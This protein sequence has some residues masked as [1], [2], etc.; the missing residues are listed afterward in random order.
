[1]TEED[2]K[3]E[4]V[5]NAIISY[6]DFIKEFKT[7]KEDYVITNEQNN[8]KLKYVFR[9]YNLDCFIIDKKYLDE[10]RK[11]TN[12]DKLTQ[13]LKDNTEENKNK[14]KKKLTEYLNEN[15]YRFDEE[16][17]KLYS[18]EDELKGIVNNFNSYS[19]VN[20]EICEIMGVS[21][22]LLNSNVVKISKNSVNT[23]LLFSKNNFIISINMDKN[24]KEN[25]TNENDEKNKNKAIEAKDGKI[26]KYKNLY[27]VEEITK[28]I[29]ALL[30]FNE[31]NIQNK[32][33][34]K[35]KDIYNFKKYYLIKS[36]WLKEYKEHFLYDKI[37]KIISDEFS[38]KNFT[39]KKIK[40]FLNDI[41]KSKIGQI[42]LS[43]GTQISNLIRNAKNLMCEITQKK[44]KIINDD[45][46]E[47]E[48]LE[49]EDEEYFS[50]PINFDLIDEDLFNLLMKEEFF[51][52]IDDNLKKALSFNV[53]IGNNQIIIN[54]KKTEDN[55]EKFKYSYEYLFYSKNER[56]DENKYELQYILNFNKNEDFFNTLEK[57]INEGLGKY[58]S[59]F[60][61]DL[62][63]KKSEIMICDDKKNI[64]GKFANIELSEKYIINHLD[65]NLFENNEEKDKIIN[66]NKIYD[67]KIKSKN[68]KKV[69]LQI[70]NFKSLEYKNEKKKHENKFEIINKENLQFY[71]IIKIKEIKNEKK[72]MNEKEFNNDNKM[73]K[74]IARGNNITINDD[75]N[76]KK[77]DDNEIFEEKKEINLPENEDNYNNIKQLRTEIDEVVKFFD[78]L[79]KID[80]I[81]DNLQINSLS[82]D[83]L[84]QRINNSEKNE[85]ILIDQKYHKEF[86]SFIGFN[87]MNDYKNSKEEEK[88][89]LLNDHQ[90]E[91]LKIR[92]IFNSEEENN[93]NKILLTT[94][95]YD[96]NKKKESKFLILNKSIF[97][98]IC[99]NTEYIHIYYILYQNKTYLYFK[100]D[101][102]I[103]EIKKFENNIFTI[104]NILKQIE[105]KKKKDKENKKENEKILKDLQAIESQVNKNNELLKLNPDKNM[106]EHFF[107]ECYLINKTW[108]N[109][110]INKYK[111][112]E[113]III[114]ESID[115]IEM[116]PKVK[117][118]ECDMFK[119]PVDFGFVDKNNYE[120]IIKDLISKKQNINIEDFYSAQIFI[121]NYQNNIPKELDKSYPNQKFIGLKIDNKIIFYIQSKF[122]LK[123]EF[124][125][126]YENEG[127]NINEE[128][129]KS[130]MKKGIGSYINNN[131]VNFSVK[132]FN[133]IDNDFNEIGFCINFDINK[134]RLYKKEKTKVLKGAKNSYFLNNVLICLLYI[135]ELKNHFSNKEKLINLIED[136][137]IFSKYFYKIFTS[138]WSTDDDDINNDNIYEKLKKE[139]INKAESNNILNNI[140]LL[141]EFL[142]LK[143]HNEIRTDKDK[144]K[145]KGD[146]IRLDEM[147]K[148]FIDINNLFYPVN[149]SIIKDL[150]FFELQTSYKCPSCKYFENQFFIKSILEIDIKLDQKSNKGKNIENTSI[151]DYL[152]LNQYIKC[153]DCNYICSYKNKINT[154]PKILIVVFN[155]NQKEKVKF[156]IDEEIDI[157]DYMS[158]KKQ[159][160]QTKYFLISTII[161]NSLTY[162]K[163]MENN[164]WYKFEGDVLKTLKHFNN[165]INNVPY[166]LI[167]KQ[168]PIKY[169]NYYK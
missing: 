10:F 138:M 104:S 130:I 86:N 108:L 32:L 105:N 71:P 145:I 38:N 43:R 150:F 136:N 35:I 152:N 44:V 92:K 78:Y 116:S 101:K 82:P 87:L 153:K 80:D 154:C 143:I 131:G 12:F 133:L 102:R 98:L 94:N 59:D 9:N 14:F 142:L 103:I 100:N 93:S 21:E 49:P 58:I 112:K 144:I 95:F 20:K 91:F 29:F 161:N 135:K 30:Y 56:D 16:E 166:L 89:K 96:L 51:I 63:Q 163:S 17:I 23:A 4:E 113:D 83:E 159:Y 52:N 157:Y 15:P 123:F 129:Q 128:I 141:I 6:L 114:K 137:S 79:F 60:G 40:Y 85:V 132:Y 117:E 18:T 25:I 34:K 119:Y 84:A 90:E 168:K 5:A 22:D 69:I 64:I 126:N 139:I 54:N 62:E 165:N 109:S 97:Q 151:Y 167:Y 164:D 88:N 74:N 146:F 149:Y 121:V 156:H 28:K 42:S 162:C 118:E 36:K 81:K 120:S 70:A 33:E 37:S 46:K 39:Y 66:E 148:S 68:N 160:N 65:K 1:M 19:F 75:N 134:R 110:E 124:L 48:T 41:I 106:N 55:E 140:S 155:L 31:Q 27:Y 122:M 11:A 3:Y 169:F 77:D 127:I 72:Q 53:L 7:K 158:I 67:D 61:V 2:Q 73:N 8:T 125:I 13:I 26:E 24:K 115:T 50:H 99:K 107:K 147:Y 57:I 76:P 45:N 47:Q 111:N